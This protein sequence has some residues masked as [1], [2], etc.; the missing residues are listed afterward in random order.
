M[1][2]YFIIH[3]DLGGARIRWQCGLARIWTHRELPRFA[4]WSPDQVGMVCGYD[5][6]GRCTVDAP[7]VVAT[8]FCG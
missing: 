2:I 8:R 3:G 7:V 6:N 4:D 1:V 5:N